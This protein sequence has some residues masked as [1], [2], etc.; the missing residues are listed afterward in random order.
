MITISKEDIEYLKDNCIDISKPMQNDDVEKVLEII[1]DAIVHNIVDNNDE[2][3][4]TGIYLQ[5]IYDR[6]KADNR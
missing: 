1:D 2:P 3:D 4:E 6:I 5:R